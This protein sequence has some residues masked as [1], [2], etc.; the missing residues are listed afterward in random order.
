MLVA[1]VKVA[2]KSKVKVERAQTRRVNA[3]LNFGILGLEL[4]H[5]T[6]SFTT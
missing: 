1:K 6:G 5:K 3:N 4:G 2:L